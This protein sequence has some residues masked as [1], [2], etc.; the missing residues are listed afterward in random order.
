M[1]DDATGNPVKQDKNGLVFSNSF[2]HLN[3][4][5]ATVPG[6]S[7]AV[8]GRVNYA[9]GTVTVNSVQAQLTPDLIFAA[10][11]LPFS[12]GTN[13]LDTVFTD[14]FGRSTNR[15]TS[16]VVSQNAYGYDANGNLTNDGRHAYFWN[17]ENRL[18]AVRDAKTGALL[19]ENHYDGLGRRRER[20][21]SAIA[22]GDDP[23]S[24]NR[25]FYQGWLVLTVTDGE[26]NVLE[27]YTN[28]ADLSGRVGGGAGGIGG[29]LASTQAGGAVY[30]HYDFNVNI[31]QV[32]SNNQTQLAKYTYS[33]FGEVMLKEGAF[34]PRYQFSTKE[35]DA[36][37]KLNYY[38]YRYYGPQM[39]RWINRDRIRERGGINLY[40]GKGSVL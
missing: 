18:V 38:G 10:I 40:S 30:Y 23:G 25:Y 22:G 15:Q 9:G 4:N 11:G 2:N 13:A 16:V 21:Q 24:T 20:I 36:L 19:Q 32:S 31:V 33:P 26:G 3:Q 1:R 34:T 27:T 35:Y 29:I 37:S 5:V 39:G 8:L 6:G 17:D 28:G 14:P 12:L 7:L